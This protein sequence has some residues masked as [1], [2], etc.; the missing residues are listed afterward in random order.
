VIGP[1]SDAR[2]YQVIVQSECGSLLASQV[3]NVQVAVPLETGQA[4]A[5]GPGE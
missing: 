5:L 3:D 2:R 1:A 4:T